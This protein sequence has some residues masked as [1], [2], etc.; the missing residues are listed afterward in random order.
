MKENKKPKYSSGQCLG[1]LFDLA[2]KHQ[3]SVLWM[4]VLLALVQVGLNLTQLYVAPEILSKVESAAPLKELLGTIALFTALLMPLIGLQYYLSEVQTAG[5]IELRSMILSQASRKSCNTSYPNTLDPHFRRLGEA[6]N[7]A[8]DGNDCAMEETWRTMTTLLTDLLGFAIYL[9]LLSRVDWVLIVLTL[10]ASVTSYLCSRYTERWSYAHR[11]ERHEHW[12]RLNYVADKAQSVELAKDVRIFGIGGWLREIYA[13]AQRLQEDY[14]NRRARQFVKADLVQWVV[15]IAR[16]GLSYGYLIH[17]AL[18]GRMSAAEFLLYFSAISG[19]VRWITGI[20]SDGATLRRF[21]LEL[22]SVLEYLNYPEPFRFE[23]GRPIPKADS[24]QL[25]L[26]HVS[27]RY[28]GSEKN[29][30]TDLNLTIAPGEKLAVVGLNGAGKTTL[31]KLLCGFFDPDEGKVTL[32]D[33]DIREFNRQE[34]YGLLCAVFQEFSVLDASVAENVAQSMDHIDREKVERCLQLAGL[35]DFI[36]S[37]PQGLDTK[38]GRDVFLD[39]VLFSGGQTQRLMLARALYK[40][41]A[42][43][44]L[45]EPTAALDPLAENDIYRKY[46]EMSAGKTSLFISH[47]LASTRF[48]DRI[49]FLADGKITEEGTHESLLAKGGAYAALFAVQSRYYQEGGELRGE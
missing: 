18:T 15:T 8:G 6:V 10:A 46:N 37:L 42:L 43:L 2:W 26:E 20:L 7:A 34:Y 14:T 33:V 16:E 49:V 19:F 1:Y 44:V 40:G 11:E 21:C 31:V 36:R 39:G 23:G 13:G 17:M 9:I 29:L 47:R 22:S 30:F 35:D 38:V 25:K 32:N 28:P 12:Q 3:K 24:Y 27:F 41:G 48:C 4:V 45:D 5:Q